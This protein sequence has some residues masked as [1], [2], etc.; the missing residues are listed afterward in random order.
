MQISADAL[1]QRAA[2]LPRVDMKKPC[3]VIGR[4][5]VSA[6]ESGLSYGYVGLVDGLVRRMRD[7][8]G[9]NAVCIATG[10]L[11]S[12]IAPEVDLIEYVYP[13]LTLQGLRMVWGE[14]QAPLSGAGP[15]MNKDE[16]AATSKR[17]SAARTTAT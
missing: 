7:E 9:Q 14:K 16:Y 11:A 13:D 6:I 12:V 1:F 8:L 17:I 5:T 2:R 3:E 4:T 10:G 15:G